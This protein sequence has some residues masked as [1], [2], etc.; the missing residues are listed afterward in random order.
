MARGRMLSTKI[1]ED[2][3]FNQM[4]VDAQFM[5]MRTVPHL[6]RDGII[7]GNP[8]LLWAKVAP[9]LPQY[10]TKM[11]NM[12]AEWVTAGFVLQY[13]DEKKRSALHIKGFSK[14][15]NGLRYDR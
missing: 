10:A 2:E 7:T 13:T 9:L 12:I 8:T 11:Q 6:D 3:D 1:A 5:F 14:N 4:S 15:Q